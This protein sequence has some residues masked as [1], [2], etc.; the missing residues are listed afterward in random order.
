IN[1]QLCNGCG[2]CCTVCIYHALVLYGIPMGVDEI[3]DAVRKDKMFYDSSGGGVTVS[4]GEALLHP[5]LIAGLFEKCRRAGIHTCIET[6]GQADPS[7]IIQVL[8]LTDY[9]LFDLKHL[10]AEKHRQYTGQNNKRI[11]ANARVAADSGVEI[12]FRMPLLPGINDDLPNI[13][14]TAAFLH[15]LG[16]RARRLELMPY[17]SLGKGKYTSLGR[18]YPLPDIPVP[19]REYLESVKN[20]FTALDIECMISG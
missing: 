8:E 16:S 9:I 1:R 12:L 11:V 7:A 10:D 13:Q 2:E 19:D 15:S 6:S 3:F 5:E 17:H 14:A 4:G 20:K 18:D